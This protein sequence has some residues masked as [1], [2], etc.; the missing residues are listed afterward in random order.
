MVKKRRDSLLLEVPYNL[1]YHPLPH[2]LI[3]LLEQLN[4]EV[5]V[6]LIHQLLLS[7]HLLLS[8]Q[9]VNFTSEMKTSFS[10]FNSSPTSASTLTFEKSSTA[11]PLPLP[12]VHPPAIPIARKIRP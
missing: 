3:V 9:K 12:P 7:T 2:Q 10:P 8:N 11:L 6:I 4:L 1:A 5:L